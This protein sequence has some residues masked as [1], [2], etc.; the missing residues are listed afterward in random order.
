MMYSHTLSASI[1]LAADLFHA[2]DTGASETE[3]ESKREVL[4]MGLEVFSE[5]IQSKVAS[6]HLRMIIES[7]RRVLTCVSSLLTA[8]RAFRSS[9]FPTSSFCSG[10][11]LEQ[12]KRRARRA[13]FSVTGEVPSD[14]KPFAEVSPR[15]IP[16]PLS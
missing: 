4:A 6:K 16:S 2:I 11:F 9:D 1:V 14:E 13:A 15:C 3:T 7:A 8:S 10:L 12:E 5:K